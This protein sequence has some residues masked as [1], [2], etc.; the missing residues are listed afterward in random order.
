MLLLLLP[1]VLQ[2]AP[3]QSSHAGSVWLRLLLPLP[4]QP[5]Q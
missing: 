4:V 1:L 2:A 3:R 5:H